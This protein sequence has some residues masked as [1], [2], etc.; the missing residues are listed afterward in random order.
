MKD[1]RSFDEVEPETKLVERVVVQVDDDE[2][3]PC[4]PKPLT[5]PD[6]PADVPVATEVADD[7]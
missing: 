3:E 5:D 2:P 6:W 4:V 7:P 1:D